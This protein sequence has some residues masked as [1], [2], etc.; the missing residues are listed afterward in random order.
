MRLAGEGRASDH[1]QQDAPVEGHRVRR[2]R[3]RRVGGARARPQR[4]AAARRA[5]HRAGVAGGEEPDGQLVGGGDEGH[6]RSDAP[7]RRLS[8]LQHHRGHAARHLRAVRKGGRGGWN[9]G[10]VGRGRG[11]SE[12]GEGAKEG[13]GGDALAAGFVLSRL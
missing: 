7:L 13:C 6:R 2:V 10:R 11:G 8:P 5:D 1:G 9:G 3:R 4:P 12:G